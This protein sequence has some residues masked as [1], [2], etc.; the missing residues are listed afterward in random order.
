MLRGQI[1][2]AEAAAAYG[3]SKHRR[4]IDAAQHELLLLTCRH[5]NG[6][7]AWKRIEEVG[8]LRHDKHAAEQVKRYAAS[9]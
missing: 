9:E 7:V 5:F 2:A 6:I 4:K 3:S 1:A 8:V